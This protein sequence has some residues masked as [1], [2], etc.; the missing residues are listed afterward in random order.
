M[1]GIEL[2]PTS[3]AASVAGRARKRRNAPRASTSISPSIS[4]SPPGNAPETSQH[5]RLRPLATGKKKAGGAL[6]GSQESDRTPP[7]A[8]AQD[9]VCSRA[10]LPGGDC[11]KHQA[12]GPLPQPSAKATARRDDLVSNPRK[13]LFLTAVLTS[14]QLPH[15]SSP[16]ST[17][18]P[19]F[20]S[21]LVPMLSVYCDIN[22]LLDRVNGVLLQLRRPTDSPAHYV[23]M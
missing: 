5:S 6:R 3:E 17:P 4:M 15:P 21:Y 22:D 13:K 1:S 2:V 10:V 16:F 23:E 19:D 20:D 9:E 8:V 12:V 14:H 18:T 11:A 7:P